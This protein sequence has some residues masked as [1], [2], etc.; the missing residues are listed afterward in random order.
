MIE[1]VAS[2]DHVHAI[3]WTLKE[4]ER[5]IRRLKR[6]FP[7]YTTPR[8]CK[9]LGELY[10]EGKIPFGQV[11]SAITELFEES[12]LLDDADRAFAC[13][14]GE[15]VSSLRT[16]R[17]VMGYVFQYLTALKRSGASDRKIEKEAE[18][19]CSSY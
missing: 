17:H 7:G 19:M 12:M 9:R 1:A 11:E 18:R 2:Q 6:K 13:S 14:V 8:D 16:K 15:G 3:K 5:P 10:I 4:I